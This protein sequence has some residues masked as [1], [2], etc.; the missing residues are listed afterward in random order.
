MFPFANFT[1]RMA[2][3]LAHDLVAAVVAVLAAFYIRFEAPGLAQRWDLLLLLLP[4]FVLY[5]AGVF[6][7]FGLYKNK[8]R[9]TSLPDLMNIIKV[10]TVLAV[11]LLVLDY[12]LLAP[13]IYGTFFF[14][15]ITI[16]LYWF[17][18]VFFLA[19]SRVAYRYFRYTRTLQHARRGDLA[20]TIVLGPA[21]DAEVL[22]R[23]I[24]SGAVKK[25]E[26]LGILSQSRADRS[27]SIRGIPVLGEFDDLERVV[28]DFAG[29]GTVVTRLVMTPTALAP[30]MKPEVILTRARR[31]G[32][33][34]SRMPSL[35]GGQALQLAPVNVEDLLLRPSAKIDYQRL[36]AFVRGKAAV[37]TG[38]G[39]SIGAE[40]CDRLA[41]YGIARLMVIEN[42][43]PALHAV[44]EALAAKDSRA[45]IDGRIADI[46]DRE[47]VIRLI[48]PFKPDIVFHAAAL[49]HVPLLERDWDEGIKTNVFGSINVA[50]AALAAG[51]AAMVMIS[52]DKAIEPTSMLGATK[53]LAEMYCQALDGDVRA[54]AG[55][56]RPPMRL[57]AVRFGNVLASNG[58][59]VPKFKAQ[60]EKRGPVT[61]THPDMVRY[62][63]TIREA[64][65]LVVTAASHALGPKA[66]D[67]S[68]YVLNMG[69]P[70]KI[71]DLAER[72]I[73]LS[74]L[75]PGRDVEIVFSGIRPGERLNE[76]L[77]AAD[78]PTADIGVAGI[79]AARPVNPALD[80]LRAWLAA[81]EQGLG[82][83]DREAIYRV[84]RD[85]VPGFRK[86]AV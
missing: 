68:V 67:V 18:Q 82:R 41:T 50:D 10:S 8:W 27:Q 42:S 47:R 78:E 20:P 84:L 1:P 40:I 25:I 58:S 9:F 26:V 31:L 12:V 6:S 32:L 76:V 56:G 66:A 86:E 79:V 35:E 74:G 2:L 48:K 7:I 16:A 85:A 63:M 80:T 11:T 36:E 5:S 30:E 23:G 60:I 28:Q 43:E 4:G 59:V 33:T 70:V 65:D 24:E 19:G 46:R 39:G 62:F 14:G 3:I 53:R 49:K 54:R 77:F 15:K 22:L 75:E 45:E 29:R 34:P 83:D 81:L 37:V 52:T 17:L 57:I 73:R 44:L 13:N 69:Q 72:M 38:G 64:C 61:V 51:A 55:S 71:V 21:A